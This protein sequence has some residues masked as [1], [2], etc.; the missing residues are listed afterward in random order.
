MLGSGFGDGDA[1]D[2]A[3][4]AIQTRDSCTTSGAGHSNTVQGTM[5]YTGQCQI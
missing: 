4:A 5:K 3:T 1:G 2:G